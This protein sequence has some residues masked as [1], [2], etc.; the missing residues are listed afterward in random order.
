MKIKKNL[1]KLNL[2]CGSFK[3]ENFVNVDSNP[4]VKPDVLHNLDEFPYPF[5]SNRFEHIEADHVL[6]HLHHPLEA[7]TEIHR[8]L[9]PGGKLIIRVPHSSRGFTHP[10]HKR[11]F[12]VTLPYYFNQS[13]K[14]GF[15]G[16]EYIKDTMQM[17]WFAQP[18][19]KKD[20]LHPV[21]FSIMTVLGKIIDRLANINPEACS[22]IWCYWVGGFEEIEYVLICKKNYYDGNH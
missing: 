5:D 13:F 8:I 10:D 15:A 9:T 1:T 6:E 4:D 20:I 17:H 14:G 21:I 16:V 11:G 12:D 19:L 18:Y 3:K 2:G 22:R 7:I